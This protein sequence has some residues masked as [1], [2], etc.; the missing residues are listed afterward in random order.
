MVQVFVP[1]G[2]TMD[3]SVFPGTLMSLMK[4]SRPP[5]VVDVRK[6]T[7]FEADPAM[8]PRA[9]WRDPR[10]V[11]Q[12]AAKLPPGCPVVVYCVHGHEV[13]R[14]VRDA[15]RRRGVMAGIME[16]GIEGW[17]AAG[18]PVVPTREGDVP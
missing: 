14:G 1:G 11:E 12:W 8:L 3:P 10:A 15:L 16:G 5:A 7:A 17:R 13:S 6:R 18:G 4:T 2:K 9:V